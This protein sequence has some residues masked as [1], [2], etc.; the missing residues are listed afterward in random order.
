MIREKRSKEKLET[1]YRK[2]MEEGIIDKDENP[3]LMDEFDIKEK[4]VSNG[5][6][7]VSKYFVELNTQDGV[8]YLP[9]KD[10]YYDFVLKHTNEKDY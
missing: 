8:K 7:V 10:Y 1:Y 5:I 6:K 9:V 2:F 4:L 3:I